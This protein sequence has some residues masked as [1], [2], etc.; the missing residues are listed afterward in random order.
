[1]VDIK[2][3]VAN[4]MEFARGELANAWR[5][6]D[7]RLEEIESSIAAGEPVWLVTLSSKPNENSLNPFSQRSLLVGADAG[8]DYK[9]FTVSK[10][11]GDV[12][13]MKIRVFAVPATQ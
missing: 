3:A 5:V 13:S 9:V 12:L 7:L 11:T 8:R 2:T 6:S 4:A 1:M 10:A